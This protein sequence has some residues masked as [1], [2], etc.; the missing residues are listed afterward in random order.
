MLNGIDRQHILA[1]SLNIDWPGDRHLATRQFNGSR[2]VE[3]DRVGVRQ[4]IGVQNGLAE[5][6]GSRVIQVRDGESGQDAAVFQTLQPQR[7]FAGRT[8]F[9]TMWSLKEHVSFP[10]GVVIAKK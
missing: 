1:W 8:I 10:E 3:L 9:P 4:R 6:A 2:H 7:S 5:T